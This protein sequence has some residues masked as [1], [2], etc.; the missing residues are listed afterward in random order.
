MATISTN[1]SA[2][3][4]PALFDAFLKWLSRGTE[5]YIASRSRRAEIEA[6]EAKS[7][8]EL[9]RMGLTRDRIALYV[10]ADRFYI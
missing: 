10:F 9:A 4:L 1:T 5:A 6:L 7:D 2:P 3:R 8:A